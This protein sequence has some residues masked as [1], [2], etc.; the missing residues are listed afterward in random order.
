MRPTVQ[1]LV[2]GEGLLSEGVAYEITHWSAD[3]GRTNT[4]RVTFDVGGLEL[5][6]EFF[7]DAADHFIEEFSEVATKAKR[8]DPDYDSPWGEE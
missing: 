4:V 8:A 3:E 5:Q 6:V 1:A 7:L 2:T